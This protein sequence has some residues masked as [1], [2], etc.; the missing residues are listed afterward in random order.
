MTA[1]APAFLLGFGAT[2]GAGLLLSSRRPRRR[3]G[4]G[5]PAEA[6]AAGLCDGMGC[7]IGEMNGRLLATRDLRPTLVTGGTRSGKG[8][9]H[10]IP[11]LLSWPE[12][13]LVHDP[14]GELWVQTA[15]WRAGFSHVMRFAPRDPRSARFNPLAEIRPGAGEV[16]A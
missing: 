1:A 9:G 7:V 15:G 3:R 16:A 14:K 12:S 4:W 2:L 8:R 11:T 5:G 10:V 6:R 13:V